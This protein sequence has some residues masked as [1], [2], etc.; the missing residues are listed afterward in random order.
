ME[1]TK[2]IAMQENLGL[3]HKGNI[4][5]TTEKRV[6]K[7]LP[8]IATEIIDDDFAHRIVLCCNSHDELVEVIEAAL[9]IKDIWTLPT[10]EECFRDEA[11]ALQTMLYKF[12]QALNSA[13][14][15]H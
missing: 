2:L 4:L 11:Q 12:E 15:P 6:D 9:R 1:H 3:G 13:K 8:P 7:N 10:D 14:S 5:I